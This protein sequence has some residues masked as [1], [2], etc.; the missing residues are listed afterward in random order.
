MQK[1][2]P[3][4]GMKEQLWSKEPYTTITLNRDSNM[5]IVWIVVEILAQIWCLPLKRIHN[6][7]KILI[8]IIFL[9]W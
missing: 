3:N 7:T 8:F 6:T 4:V 9:N 2:N 5:F 1:K